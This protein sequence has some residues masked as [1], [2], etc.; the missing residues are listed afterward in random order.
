MNNHDETSVLTPTGPKT[1]D[2]IIIA[3]KHLM[4]YVWE[5]MIQLA[6]KD[7]ITIRSSVRNE[8]VLNQLVSLFRHVGVKEKKREHVRINLNK[9]N[10]PC[11]QI[12]LEKVG[13]IKGVL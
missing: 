2:T 3:T 9:E 12:T 8:Y 7:E 4:V 1:T 11:V 5:M 10:V 13:A 6:E